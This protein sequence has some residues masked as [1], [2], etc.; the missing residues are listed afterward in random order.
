MKTVKQFR[1]KEL[2]EHSGLSQGELAK[3]LGV[4]TSQLSRWEKGERQPSINQLMSIARALG[5]TLDYLLNAELSVTFKFRSKKLLS[6]EEKKAIEKALVD[7][8]M[9]IHYL[10]SAYKLAKKIPRQ[11]AIK[12]DYF[13]QQL[14]TIVQQLRET[15][16]LNQRITLEEF[17]QAL[18]ELNIH[19][20]EW[21]LPWELSGL[22]Y[23][24]AF[25]VIF[26]NRLHTK[27]RRLFTLAHEFAHIL[28][29]A[30]R[31]N[32]QTLVSTISSSRDPIEKEAHAFAA[33][34]L[35]PTN[36][37]KQI[38]ANPA[39]NIKS[40]EFVDSIA[41]FFNVSRDAIYYQLVKMGI[42]SWEEKRLYLSKHKTIPSLPATR[43]ENID[44]QVASEFL[45]TAL[46]LFDAQEISTGKLHDWFFT[47]RITLDDYLA[48]RVVESEEVFEF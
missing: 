28:F 20:F 5:V 31:D 39:I 25:A 41:R 33:E 45:R 16:K 43:V 6:N 24:D 11:F 26:I 36:M 46:E 7:A 9:Q 38:L 23:R 18:T 8:E 21:A 29:H 14:P 19:I 48:E 47:D 15:L 12:M 17:K 27:E 30:G 34:F 22:S 35:M 32:Q 37:I 42:F 3:L 10:N 1:I 40:I 13:Q 2:R 4:H 44:E